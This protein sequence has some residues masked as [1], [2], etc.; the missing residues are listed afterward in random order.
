MSF[1]SSPVTGACGKAVNSGQ[2]DEAQLAPRRCFK[3][4]RAGFDR[5]AGIFGDLA[6][7]PVSP[8]KS[9]DLP[10]FGAPTNA[11]HSSVTGAP[12]FLPMQLHFLARR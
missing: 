4:A 3:G 5:N 12:Q 1:V 7:P 8:L 6:R 2:I 11:K 9:V 10:E